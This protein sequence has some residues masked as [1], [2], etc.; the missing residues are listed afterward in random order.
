LFPQNFLAKKTRT[1]TQLYIQNRQRLV[2]DAD[3]A[4]VGGAKIRLGR[5]A[6]A[7]LAQAI[8]HQLSKDRFH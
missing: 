7:S 5:N 4:K 3:A 2:F 8:S 1:A 6:A